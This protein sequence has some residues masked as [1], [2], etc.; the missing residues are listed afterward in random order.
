MIDVG[1][2]CCVSHGCS[3]QPFYGAS[4]T[5]KAESC[6]RAI[7]G[8]TRVNSRQCESKRFRDYPRSICPQHIASV[9]ADNVS[10]DEGANGGGT[11]DDTMTE[12]VDVD[13]RGT[14]GRSS[15]TCSG[16]GTDSA[17]FRRCLLPDSAV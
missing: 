12:D 15:G 8:K 6:A 10:I 7:V 1:G 17:G 4:G 3:E 9:T 16:C 13:D 2:T 14:F 11:A 5:G